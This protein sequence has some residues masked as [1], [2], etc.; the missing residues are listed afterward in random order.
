MDTITEILE[1]GQSRV[2]TLVAALILLSLASAC[3]DTA[4][5]PSA[6]D[7]A[8]APIA[9]TETRAAIRPYSMAVA[10]LSSVRKRVRVASILIDSISRQIVECTMDCG[11]EI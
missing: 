8:A 9:A 5:I 11:L 7:E 1:S 4:V 3:Q 10:P 2:S 6:N